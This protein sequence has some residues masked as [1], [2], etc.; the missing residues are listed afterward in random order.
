MAIDLDVQP[1]PP[2]QR[3]A[4]SEASPP[5]RR[6][7]P[8]VLQMA[9]VECGAASLAMILAERGR[10]VPLDELRKACGVSRDGATALDIVAAGLTYGI[11][12]LGHRATVE[13]LAEIPSFPAIIWW[14]RSHFMVLEGVQKGRYFVNDPARGRY[15]LAQA[16]FADG[17]SGVAITFTTTE[18]FAKG[19][20]PF[21]T[22]S[23][24]WSRLRN[25]KPGLVYA[26]VAGLLAMV[27]GV[28]AAPISQLFVTEV[29]GGG[30][31]ELVLDLVGALLAVGALRAV[32]VALQYRVIVRLQAKFSLVGSA[33]FL[34][35][36]LRL[37]VEFYL[38]RTAGD[39]A[40]R[41]GKNVIVAQIVAGQFAG[42]GI[43]LIG[44][45]GYAGLMA[46][47]SWQLAVVVIGLS[48]LNV[49]ALRA[50]A[51]VRSVQQQRVL[52]EQGKLQGT[53]VSAIQSI[54]TIKAT[55]M[56]ANVFRTL[57]GQQARY[58][59][60]Q[61]G[62]VTSSA[63][64]SAIPTV[65]FSLAGAA[66]LVVGGY[67]ILEGQLTVGGLVAV[68]ALAAGINSPVQTLMGASSQLQVVSASLQSL[69]DVLANEVDERYEARPD[70]VSR[71]ADLA[72]RLTF[73]NVSFGYSIMK[74]AFIK[75][76]S[77]HLE[78]GRRIAL[79]GGSG[80]GKTTLANL[81]IG[82]LKP[83]SGRVLYAGRPLVEV[84]GGLLERTL[85][86]VDQ[87]I[88]LFEGTV[89]Q[90]VTLWD[91]TVPDD[92]V[93]RALADAQ[94]LDDV[95]ARPGGLDAFVA[96]SGR[97]FSGGQRQRMEIAR[98]LAVD[99]RIVILDEATSALD[100]TTEKLVDD[101][102]RARGVSCLIVAHRL[103]TIRDADEIVV[104]GRG[105]K[106]VERGTHTEL[107]AAGGEYASLVR[108]AGEGGHVGT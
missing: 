45:V 12:G 18:A 108:D 95:L 58:M 27:L 98:A 46:Y 105:G 77:L 88:V 6:S 87:S 97:N 91:D 76:F 49:V 100:P 41:I 99:P 36:L 23:S 54:E 74:P 68:Q 104:L 61:N 82:L 62:M 28:A 2:R 72:G 83:W 3:Q 37:P 26:V 47:Y 56:E 29:L 79:V 86:K 42:A 93:R 32:L 71:P 8:T 84:T 81:A 20:H 65:L 92:R 63:M 34:E 67:L 22:P 89:R 80:S 5:P 52:R 78:P 4:P 48:L 44:V 60:A 39:L 75:D 30:R 85:S 103:S 69:D 43:A 14:R 40:Q 17:Y 38:Q 7:V 90:N 57:V 9:A 101:A 55:G 35:R 33:G 51:R 70:D 24:V 73:E 15:V 13:K 96:E 53:T 59:S 1:K 10:W 50:V 66:I 107:L 16:D 64:L 106:V 31:R 25:T 21:R 102:L 94:L 11:Q 19:G